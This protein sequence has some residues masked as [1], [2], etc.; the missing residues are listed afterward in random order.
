[1]FSS[2]DVLEAGLQVTMVGRLES[3]R[4]ALPYPP[5]IT[6]AALARLMS[7]RFDFILG[8]TTYRG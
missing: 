3:L 4:A 5:A 6:V 1:M 8:D 7:G 2:W